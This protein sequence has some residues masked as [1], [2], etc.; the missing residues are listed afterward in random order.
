[1]GKRSK[2]PRGTRRPA[3]RK[4]GAGK[5]GPRT[6]AP[7]RPP[8]LPRRSWVRTWLPILVLVTAPAVIVAEGAEESFRLPKL[9]LSEALGLLS[10][11]VLVWRRRAAPRWRLGEVLRQPVVVAVL[12]LVLVAASGLLTSA[13]PFH[14][15]QA[16]G[17]LVIGTACLVGWSLA[18]EAAEHRR[19]LLAL[20][21]PAAILSFLAVA[22]FHRWIE[23]FQFQ[24][25]VKE[26]IAVTSLAGGVF[27]LGAYLVLPMLIAQAAFFREPRRRRR[28]LWGIGLALGLYALALTQTLTAIVALVVGSFV[29]WLGLLPWR[30]VL[31]ATALVAV[32][33]AG[34]AWGVAPLRQR[35]ETKIG[36][37]TTGDLNQVLSG[38][39]DGWWAARWMFE[40]HPWTGVGHGAY[41]AE[42]GDARLALRDQGRLFYA[43]QHQTYFSN[44]HS[45]VLEAA[46]EWG[47]PGCLALAWAI[48]C[49]LV[50]LYRRQRPAAGEDGAEPRERLQPGEA[51]LMAA[52][53]AAMAALAVANFPWRI[54]LTAYPQLLFLSWIF[55]SRPAAGEPAERPGRS[56]RQ[57]VWILVLLLIAALV[58]QLRTA[59]RRISASYQLAAVEEMTRQL[60]GRGLLS[61]RPLEAEVRRTLERNVRRLDEI[62]AFDPVEVRI[63]I[64]RGAQYLLLG[65]NRAAIEAYEAARV[66]EARSEIYANL[67]RAKYLAGDRD[68]AREAF[69]KALRL[70]RSTARNFRPYLKDLG[71]WPA[72]RPQ[73]GQESEQR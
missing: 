40:Q 15:R 39:L 56:A 16:L 67:G 42:F 47:I 52:A 13:H 48:G 55:A 17:S 9:L 51:V 35:L 43:R 49:L 46:A 41:Q 50:R 6:A 44:A 37:L 65:R 61:R 53:L 73:R 3:K 14:V 23:L 22:Q 30:R 12:P 68:G 20:L 64:A 57:T 4:R 24:E 71:M 18:L 63:P 7:R 69:T 25:V 28:W 45:E 31:A 1:M 21:L 26:R 60:A 2:S 70:N 36:S 27:D 19:L 62:S 54:A 58:L 5:S 29:L 33:G 59:G 10:L 32:V 72:P 38:R 34:F 8:V 66:L 11:L